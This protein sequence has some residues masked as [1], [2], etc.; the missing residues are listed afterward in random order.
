MRVEREYDGNMQIIWITSVDLCA[1]SLE[2]F[3]AMG[4]SQKMA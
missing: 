4:P 1:A 3:G 2:C